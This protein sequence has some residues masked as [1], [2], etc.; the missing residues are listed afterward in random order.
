ME[1]RP[2]KVPSRRLIISLAWALVV[3]CLTFA[4]GPLSSLSDSKIIALGQ[5]FLMALLLPGLIGSGLITGNI[6][7][8]P[9]TLAACITF[10]FNF[11]LAWLLYSLIA[12]WSRSVR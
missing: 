12:G 4:V 5:Q 11:G 1:N 7:A 3:G 2:R 6:H 9:I 10:F 8:F